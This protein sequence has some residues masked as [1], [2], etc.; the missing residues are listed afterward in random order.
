MK[1]VV[2]KIF[3]MFA[4]KRLCWSLFLIDFIKKRLQHRCFA[5]NIAYCE[6]FKNTYF[7][8]H[9]ERLLLD[10]NLS[11][12]NT[13]KKYIVTHQWILNLAAQRLFDKQPTCRGNWWCTSNS[14]FQLRIRIT[15]VW[16]GKIKN[17]KY[18]MHCICNLIN[19]FVALCSIN[20][21]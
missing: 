8:K 11:A 7:D 17:V 6:I 13:W 20:Y 3:A 9:L 21:Q 5:V 14:L 2:R 4:G 10:V 15:N 19:S 16:D 12:E 18:L 1:K